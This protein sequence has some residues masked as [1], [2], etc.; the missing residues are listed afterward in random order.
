METFAVKLDNDALAAG[1]QEIFAHMQGEFIPQAS[2][3]RKLADEIAATLP[4]SSS[5]LPFRLA[6]QAIL[7]EA[8]FRWLQDFT[9]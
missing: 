3:V 8:A 2:V 4:Q 7:C 5:V 6:E 1:V 9:A